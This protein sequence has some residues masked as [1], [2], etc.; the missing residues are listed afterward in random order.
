MH[1]FKLDQLTKRQTDVNLVFG[2]KTSVTQQLS[3]FPVRNMS[4]LNKVCLQMRVAANTTDKSLLY[5]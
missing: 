3:L 1:K 2:D 4:K 5:P